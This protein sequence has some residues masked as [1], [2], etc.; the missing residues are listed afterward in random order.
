MGLVGFRAAHRE[1][2]QGCSDASPTGCGAALSRLLAADS[3]SARSVSLKTEESLKT[4]SHTNEGSRA[5]IG[6]AWDLLPQDVLL[7]VLQCLGATISTAVAA[8]S[9]WS[10]AAEFGGCQAFQPLCFIRALPA[11]GAPTAAFDSQARVAHRRRVD[12]TKVGAFDWRPLAKAAVNPCSVPS[13]WSSLTLDGAAPSHR[14]SV[15]VCGSTVDHSD[16]VACLFGGNISRSVAGS[17]TTSDELFLARVN[18]SDRRRCNMVQISRST[19]APWPASRWGA[20]MSA[21]Q[22]ARYLLGGWSQSG[23]CTSLWAL[24]LREAAAEWTKV[25]GEPGAAAGPPTTAF[26]TSTA[27]DDGKRLALI[28]GLGDG[29]S[30][31]GVWL[32]QSDTETWTRACA[33]GPSCAGHAAGVFGQRLVVFG[34]VERAARGPFGDSFLGVAKVF[35]LRMNQWDRS[36]R[37][38][39]LEPKARRNPTYATVGRHLI[40]SGGWDD[41]TSRALSDTWALDISK[42]VWRKFDTVG[43]PALE[44]H[45]AVVSGFD[46][47]TFGGHNGPGRYPA[48]T[49]AVHALSLGLGEEEAASEAQ[50]DSAS[51]TGLESPE[52]ESSDDDE[53]DDGPGGGQTLV[54][55]PNGRVVS[56]AALQAL[57]ARQRQ[58]DD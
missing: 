44:G 37:V 15:A 45:K 7:R 23:D 14:H 12:P 30:V 20:S 10:R 31:S 39:G 11:P 53:D 33:E 48:R 35:D 29:S 6:V 18:A 4:E 26:H 50:N 16:D 55:L 56:L 9:Q 49:L 3:R 2:M 21:L 58:A 17:W 46:L 36:T 22:P 25:T 40:I 34:G 24:R 5:I 42:S 57:I 54:R 1:N 28:G 38:C 27:L 47:H 43:A 19:E 51:G 41:D 8:S 13:K 52:E 32:F